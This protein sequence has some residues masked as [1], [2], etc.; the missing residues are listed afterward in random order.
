MD[1]F[2]FL[3]Y[4]F[5]GWN[6]KT[7]CNKKLIIGII[8]EVLGRKK[9]IKFCGA[10]IKNCKPNFRLN[11]IDKLNKYRTVEMGGECRKNVDINIT[12]KIKFL[13]EYKFSI[14]MENSNGGGYIS[15]KI[16]DSFLAGT[17]PIYYGDYMIDEYIN[18]KTYILINSDKDIDNKIEYIMKIDNDDNL[19]KDIMKEKPIM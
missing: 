6:N 11:C 2:K 15:E 1:L 7:R 16:I 10:V 8:K 19:Y 12:D 5:K 13:S 18:P 14:A 4:K 3:F 9:R 17:I